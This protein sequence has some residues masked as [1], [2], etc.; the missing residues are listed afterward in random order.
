MNNEEKIKLLG[1]ENTNLIK[2]PIKQSSL[3]F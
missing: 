2:A 3:N 1:E